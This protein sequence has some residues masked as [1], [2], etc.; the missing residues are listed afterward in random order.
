MAGASTIKPSARG[1]RGVTDWISGNK[2]LVFAIG[3]FAV[4]AIILVPLP[5]FILD[6]LLIANITFSLLILLA[7]IFAE[8]PLSLNTFPTVLLASASSSAAGRGR[9]AVRRRRP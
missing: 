7:A 9:R 4:F 6:F 2:T 8:Q 5:T 1:M 3:L